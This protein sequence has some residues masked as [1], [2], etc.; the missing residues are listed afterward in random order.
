MG[1]KF[2]FLVDAA[3]GLVRLKVGGLFS[4]D[5][6]RDF[7]AAQRAAY[8][9]LGEVKGRH[10]T[11]CD[12]SACKIQF[13]QVVEAFRSL[14]NDPALMSERMAVVTGSSPATMQ[15]RRLVDR[16]TCRFFDNARDAERWLVAD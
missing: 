13:Y 9:K 11:L 5:D 7:A 14:L 12:I 15:I 10:R 8:A 6:V 3:A 1:G 4:P 16:N 2:T